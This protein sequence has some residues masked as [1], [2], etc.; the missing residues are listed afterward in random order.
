MT[1]YELLVRVASLAC[2]LDE[3]LNEAKEDKD[4]TDDQYM[5]IERQQYFIEKTS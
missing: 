2:D 1:K 4:I 3:L 5:E